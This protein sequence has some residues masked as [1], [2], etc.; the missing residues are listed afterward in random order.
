MRHVPQASSST[1]FGEV[2]GRQ[3]LTLINQLTCYS[4]PPLDPCSSDTSPLESSLQR[5]A[6]NHETPLS[7][8]TLENSPLSRIDVRS[9][10][11]GSATLGKALHGQ[12]WDFTIRSSSIVIKRSVSMPAGCDFD[13]QKGARLLLDL[14]VLMLTSPSLP[15]STV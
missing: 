7:R 11:H 8:L 2:F 4:G 10:S 5:A 3:A 13:R 12:P 14:F 9:V 15:L 1:L 6:E